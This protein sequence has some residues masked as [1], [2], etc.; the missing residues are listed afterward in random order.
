M[1]PGDYRLVRTV[2]RLPARV[3]T[4]LLI[5]FVGTAVLLVAVG[6]LGLRVLAQSNDRVSELGPLQERASAYGKLQSDTSNVRLLL[7]ENLHGSADFYAVWPE[8]RPTYSAQGSR[9]CRRGGREPGHAD[10][11]GDLPRPTGIRASRR[12]RER[13]P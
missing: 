5:A 7:A 4:K 11:T 1:S 10:R 9:S 2:G 8:S 12:G 13:P 6:A 3:H